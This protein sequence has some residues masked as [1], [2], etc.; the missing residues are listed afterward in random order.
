MATQNSTTRLMPAG[1]SMYKQS[2]NGSG[3]SLS[4][5]NG[6]ASRTSLLP[7]VQEPRY[8]TVPEGLEDSEGSGPSGYI[9]EA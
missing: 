2:Q 8:S 7:P 9:H 5:Q 3:R 1:N 4:F 6:T